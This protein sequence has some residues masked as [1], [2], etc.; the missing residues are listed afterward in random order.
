MKQFKLLRDATSQ[1]SF[2]TPFCDE[3]DSFNATKT[4][5]DSF[6]VAVPPKS[7][8]A[9]ISIQPGASFLVS[10]KSVIS[11]PSSTFTSAGLKLLQGEKY[12]STISNGAC[13]ENLYF[14]CLANANINIEFFTVSNG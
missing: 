9:L 11:A 12:I 2:G 8:G 3:Q 5:G 4:Q 10:Q 14:F 1:I 7:T 13:V 6:T